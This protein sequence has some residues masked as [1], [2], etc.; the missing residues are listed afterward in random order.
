VPTLCR[1]ALLALL[2]LLATGCAHA[3]A[4]PRS[5]A[6]P[7]VEART[8]ARSVILCTT[9]EAELRHQFGEPTRDGIL[10]RARVLSWIMRWDSP[11]RYLAVLLDDRGVVVDVYW[12][13]P[14][15]VAWEPTDQCRGR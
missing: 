11:A 9:T 10:H 2:A 15:E 6:A 13:I 5:P 1:R 14:S 8:I 7:A 12:D 3:A 4:A